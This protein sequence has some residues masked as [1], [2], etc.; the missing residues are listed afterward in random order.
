MS[1]TDPPDWTTETLSSADMN[2]YVRD[3]T[4]DLHRRTTAVS[5][6]VATAET[7]S[8][9]SYTNLTTPG[10][11]VDVEVGATGAAVVILTA[12]VEPEFNDGD[13]LMSYKVSGAT[14]VSTSDTRALR[15]PASNANAGQSIQASFMHLHT[16]LT[17]GV[18]T[19]TAWYKTDT[20]GADAT[21]S[22]REITVIPLGA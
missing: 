5:D 10:P 8:L 11:E 4:N 21:F 17:P 16:G 18:N 1:W 2:A 19:F 7:T 3:N 15:L 6:V 22:N 20:G 13:A 12:R 9:S 14:T